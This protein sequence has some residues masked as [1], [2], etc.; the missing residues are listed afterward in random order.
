V[1]LPQRKNEGAIVGDVIQRRAH[2]PA[3]SRIKAPRPERL[4]NSRKCS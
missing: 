2:A 3:G 1:P 4:R